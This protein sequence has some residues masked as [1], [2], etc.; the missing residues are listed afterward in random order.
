MG[1]RKSLGSL[2][3]KYA[4]LEI[5]YSAFVLIFFAILFNILVNINFIYPA[6]HAEVNIFKVEELLKKDDF[7]PA[8][9][10][11]YYDYKY[12]KD[13]Q[14]VEN[15]IDQKYQNHVK[16]AENT[17]ISYTNSIIYAKYFKKLTYK[18]KNLILAYQVSPILASEKLY[19]KIKNVELLYLF[20]S[21]IIWLMG[22]IYL[23][24]KTQRIIK[25]EINLIATSNENIRNMN[26][27]YD[28]KISRYTEIQ[29]VLD[30][31]D[32][33][34]RDLKKSLHDQWQTEKNQK[35]LIESITHDIRTPITLIKGNTELLKEESNS[36]QLEYINGLETGIDRL[37]IY[38]KKLNTF[39]KNMTYKSQVVNENV[40]DYWIE[41]ARTIT[42][43]EKI[44]LV[45]TNNDATDIKLNKEDIARALQNLIVNACEH[46]PKDSSIYLSFEDQN[47]FYTISVKDNG[48]GFTKEILDKGPQ[49]KLTTKDDK[50]NHG[51]GLIIVDELVKNNNGRL[52]ISNHKENTKSGGEV[53]MTFEK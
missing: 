42:N 23:I 34:A 27:D 32:I 21:F 28:R 1:N 3:S 50:M 33:M 46:S 22:F 48:E 52:E 30:S 40:I 25:S 49:K 8:D 24:R 15:T 11:Y 35:N 4:I 14:E 45:I 38:I 20:L 13:G 9:I 12:Y 37:E 29:G 43:T 36:S 31:L 16:N 7:N 2:I 18:D 17:G 5:I 47:D 41:L 10:P 39:S 53:K 44:E 51:H 6:N 19:N 26:L